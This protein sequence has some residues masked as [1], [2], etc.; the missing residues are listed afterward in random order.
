M[1]RNEWLQNLDTGPKWRISV[2]PK[3]P[4][5]AI[6]HVIIGPPFSTFEEADRIAQRLSIGHPDSYYAVV[7][8]EKN[9]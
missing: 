9:G 4:Q 3:D 8:E 1:D 7:E 5:S 2:A 6:G